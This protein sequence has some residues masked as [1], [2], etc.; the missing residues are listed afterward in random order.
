MREVYPSE[1]ADAADKAFSRARREAL[2]RRAWAKVRGSPGSVELASFDEAKA[3]LIGTERVRLGIRRVALC[4]IVGS[5]ARGGDFDGRFLPIKRE[6]GL[7]WK[8][9]YRAFQRYESHGTGFP[10]VSLYQIDRAYFVRDGN[11]RVSVSRFR[12]W[13]TIEADVVLLRSSSNSRA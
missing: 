11:H 10:P 4:D 9:V 2:L 13:E 6:L 8:Q 7:R 1:A 3:G 5:V 12:G